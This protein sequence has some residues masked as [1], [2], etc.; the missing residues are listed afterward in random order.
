M[1]PVLLL[2]SALL[3]AP[4]TVWAS[5]PGLAR[6]GFLPPDAMILEVLEASPAMAEARA[7][8]GGARADERA[9][10]AGD[11]ETLLT[12]AF[13]ERRIRNDRSYSEW[14]VQA[15]RGLRLPGKGALDRAAG[16]AGVKAAVN[17]VDDARHQLSLVL[18]EQWIGWAEVAELRTIDAAEAETYANDVAALDRRVAEKDAAQMDLETARGAEARA[19]AALAQTRGR[20]RS[21]KADLDAQFPTLAPDIAPTLPAPV[22]PSRPLE[23][24]ANTILQRSHEITIARALAD[25]EGLLARRARQDRVP[26]PTF[27][28]RTFSERGGEETGVGLFVSI[29]FSGPRR[30]A[31]AD[32]HVA[33]ASAAEARY[34]LVE[35]QVR[36]T[37]QADVIAAGA[38]LE[39][40]REAR[41]SS[42]ASEQAAKRTGRA[43]QLGE[44]DLADKL[45]A[46]RQAFEARR[47]ELGARAEAHRALLK[48]ALDAHELWL[49]D[50]D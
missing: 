43:Y 15:S 7:M 11:H 35:R 45:L 12:T 27:G 6:P 25:Q 50:E 9:L 21:A 23:A 29:P 32:R 42:D 47:G 41:L 5:E 33:D 38:A 46:Q 19:R 37:A 49:A 13:D 16:A 39:V 24:W 26:D 48:L 2:A 28:V 31:V 1:R 36:A 8:L 30:S 17:S 4:V 14:S 3:L 44:L 34:A 40:W 10:A 22:G 20:E 18:A